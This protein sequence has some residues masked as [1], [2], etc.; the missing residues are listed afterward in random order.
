MIKDNPLIKKL[1]LN[2]VVLGTWI[3]IPSSMVADI[4]ASVGLDFVVVD[5]E[6]SPISYE[7]AQ[8]I[9][10]ACES[11]G[12]SPAVRV[13]KVSEEQILKAC[14]I[15]AHC[16][17]IPNV[18]SVADVKLIIN[19]AKYPPIGYKGFSPFNRNFDYTMENSN[20]TELLNKN[21]LIAIHIEDNKILDHGLENILK[22][23]ID[24]VFIG[25][26]DISKSL[27]KVFIISSSLGNH[28]DKT[29]SSSKT[30]AIS[31]SSFII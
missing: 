25:L 21:T 17:H 5:C 4:I 11:R 8:L 15:G 31:T 28:S 7:T 13:A 30:K 27:G 12:V 26:F 23:P 18:R 6:H 22:E 9:I 20:K 14:D 19:Y 2:E 1:S 3:T 16:I 29:I 10:L 24:I